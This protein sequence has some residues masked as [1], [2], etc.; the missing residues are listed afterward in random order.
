MQILQFID[1]WFVFQRHQSCLLQQRSWGFSQTCWVFLQKCWGFSQKC[2]G[3]SLPSSSP[4]GRLLC[5]QLNTNITAMM[6]IGLW[7]KIMWYRQ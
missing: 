4:G 5:L 1:F 7:T 2:W 6:G 3:F